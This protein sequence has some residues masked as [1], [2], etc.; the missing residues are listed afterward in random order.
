[1][2]QKVKSGDI[3][4]FKQWMDSNAKRIERLAVQYGCTQEL[5]GNVTEDIFRTLYKELVNLDEDEI[6]IDSLYE[7]AVNKLAHVPLR[8]PPETTIFRF[9]E[10]QVLHERINQLEEK[11]KITFI[12]SQFHNIELTK[13]AQITGLTKEKAEYAIRESFQQ[14][15]VQADRAVVEKQLE[16]LAK[17]YKRISYSFN[18]EA[19]FESSKNERQTSQRKETPRKKWTVLAWIS[20]IVLLLTLIIV[21]VVTSE[22]YKQASAEKYL[23][24][25]KSSFNEKMKRQYKELGLSETEKESEVD[26]H[27]GEY[28][29][30]ERLDFDLMISRYERLLAESGTFNKEK[31]DEEYKSIVKNMEIPSDM[32]NSLVRNPLTED[33]KKSETFISEYWGKVELLQQ[34]YINLL[35]HYQTLVNKAVVDGKVDIE[36]LNAEKDTY[37]KELQEALKGMANQN[38]QL[39][40]VSGWGVI[41]VYEKN[42]VGD[43]IRNS[44]HK[45]LGGFVSAIESIRLIYED[46]REEMV[47]EMLAM[48]NTLIASDHNNPPYDMLEGFYTG[49]FASLLNWHQ[50]DM[51]VDDDGN[52]KPAYRTA[53]KKAAAIGGKS[54][55]SVVMQGIVNEMEARGWTKAETFTRFQDYKLR[56]ALQLAKADDLKSFSFYGIKKNGTDSDIVTLPD[57]EFEKVIAET[58]KSFSE[59]HDLSLLTDVNPLIITGVFYYANDLEDSETMWY[60][61][62]AGYSNLTLEEY[63]SDWIQAEK[64][65]ATVTSL[66]F[67]HED[68]KNGFIEFQNENNFFTTM[69]NKGEDNVW[70]IYTEELNTHKFD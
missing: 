57:P 17:T 60:L 43:Q 36:K 19:V 45:D 51:L 38:F 68:E 1:M 12:L 49:A 31:M 67:M 55:L 63:K 34:H 25:I 16:F 69:I 24:R 65:L 22:E 6:L 58:Y 52:L 66:S 30:Q 40:A 46:K 23:E 20:G 37:P 2:N 44:I 62:S 41:A 39:T 64:A 14:I 32:V 47:E 29:A 53:W 3:E 13:I 27:I 42:E 54:P 28:G 4:A 15:S 9:E 5:A 26:F 10:D 35:M 70:R 33:K 7:I 48:E 21:P 18:K 8:I 11:D 59:N 61:D 50:P 56:D